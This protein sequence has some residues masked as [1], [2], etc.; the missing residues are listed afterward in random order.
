MLL[1]LLR[2]GSVDM[3]S[4]IVYILSVLMVIFL[5][6]PLHECAHGFVAYKLGDRTAKNMGRL[7]LNPI[8]HIDYL[9]AAMMLFVG[10]GW[11]KPVPV[12]ARNFKRPK[13]GMGLTALAGP[14]S[15]LLAAILGGLIY[16]GIITILVKNGDFIYGPD[17][18][19][20]NSLFVRSGF[21]LGILK[22]VLMFFQFFILINICLA[23]FNLIPV[24]PLDGSKI[25][26]VF[27]PYRMIYKIQRYEHVISMVLFIAI[28]MG[29]VTLFLSPIQNWLYDRIN[30]L[31]QL[32]Y[33]WSW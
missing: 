11:A 27:L 4:V 20:V 24:P 10:F 16:N 3:F 32:A 21:D 29:G 22:Y 30:N 18:N 19:G 23:V 2:S 9:G 31:T 8:S 17:E 6:N 14:V 15:N 1:S 33:S 5:I 28:M 26:M 12:N 7:T 13:L 25:L